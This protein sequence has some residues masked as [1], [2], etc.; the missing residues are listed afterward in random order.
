MV[1]SAATLSQLEPG[2]E[3]GEV[4]GVG[5]D[6]GH[7]QP[8]GPSAPGSVRH[9][10]CFWPVSSSGVVSQSCGVLGLH[11]PQVGR[12][13]PPATIARACADHRVAGVVVRQHE[14]AARLPRPAAP[15]PAHRR[16]RG[17]RLVADHVDAGVEEGR[18]GGQVQVVGRDDGDHVDAVGAARARARAISCEVAIGRARA[19]RP[20]SAAEARERSGVL[21]KQRRPPARS[22]RP[23]ARPCGARRR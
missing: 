8:P 9:A 18:G 17:Q 15:A 3:A 6:V 11:D 5:A 23:S 19:R 20:S 13:R 22:G 21:E 4:D 2:D 14:H 1:R 16:G 7:V 12:A 10:A